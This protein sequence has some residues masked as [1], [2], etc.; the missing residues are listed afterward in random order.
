MKYKVTRN[1]KYDFSGQSY[2]SFCPSLHRYPATMLPQIGIEILKELRIVH[3]S[4]L[5]PYCGS[6]SSFVS[7]LERGI[8]EMAGFDINPLAVLISKVKFTKISIDTV[9]E[10]KVKLHDAIYRF[11]KEKNSIHKMAQPCITNADYWFSKEVIQH[12]RLI[13]HFIYQIEDECVKQF[14]LLSFSETVRKCSYVKSNEHKLNRIKP[15]DIVNCNPDVL[16]I[17]FNKLNDMIFT[18]SN[19]YYPKL[20]DHIKI[21]IHCSRFYPHNCKYDVVLTSPPYGDSRT[22]VAYGQFSTLSNEWL[23]V[24]NARKIDG[25]LMGGERAKALYRKGVV[26]DTIYEISRTDNRRALEVSSF[27]CDMEES[28]G[29]VA[30]SVKKGGKIIYVVG[31]RTVRNIPLPTDQFVAEHFEENGFCHLLTYKRVMSNKV[32]P[33][34]NSPEN[35]TGKMA[36]TILY[37][38]IVVCEKTG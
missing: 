19:F 38:Y 35:K 11:V 25:L 1:P 24:E 8:T 30:K 9:I 32:M 26:S 22:T 28:I 13:R 6:G 4:L 29:E 7:G 34:N 17:F 21:G 20:N 12:L 31:N 10:I 33:S 36:N 16:S 23:G 2:A 3:G 37:E 14:F 15:E 5:D 27:Y 18:Y